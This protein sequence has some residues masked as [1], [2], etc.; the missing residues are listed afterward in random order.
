MHVIPENVQETSTTT[1]T[2]TL[3]LGGAVT[4]ALDFDS[5]LASADTTHYAIEDGVDLE[6]GIG[7]FT[8]P[9]TLTRD[10]VLYS[11]AGAGVKVNWGAG[12]RNVIGGLPGAE[13]SSLLDPADGVGF[14]SR[15][16]ARTYAARTLT[17]DRG[18]RLTNPGGVG[19]DPVISG[20]AI[21]IR[22]FGAVEGVG[23][24]V[25]NNVAFLLAISYLNSANAGAVVFDEGIWVWNAPINWGGIPDHSQIIG[26]GVV[27]LRY[28]GTGVAFNLDGGATGPGVHNLKVG[29]FLIEAP[30]TATI[31]FDARA[32]HHSDLRINVR[33]AGTISHQLAWCVANICNFQSS[34][35]QGGWYSA[36]A[37]PLGLVLNGRGTAFQTSYNT[38]IN[39]LFEGQPI[40]GQLNAALGNIFIGGAFEGCATKGLEITSSTENGNNVFLG[41][42]FEQNGPAFAGPDIDCDSRDNEFHGVDTFRNLLL[43]ANAINNKVIGGA[44]RDITLTAGAQSN[45]L[46]GFTIDRF[47]NVPAGSVIGDTTV[48][49][50]RDFTDNAGNLITEI[51]RTLNPTSFPNEVSIT[52]GASPFT[53]TNTNTVTEAVQVLSDQN[54]TDVTYVRNG[55]GNNISTTW[56]MWEVSPGDSLIVTYPDPAGPSMRAIARAK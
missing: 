35:N 37:P 29:P 4:G 3:T 8:P 40:G 16:A 47:G 7:T 43:G 24:E 32:I 51:G 54:V 45:I 38:F 30:S 20:M 23:N 28:T 41:T 19:G 12:T 49:I 44:H 34:V 46:T 15:T 55:V 10:T 13:I 11:T 33:G 39:P 48:N 21:N 31:G 5:Q 9:S 22:E 50:V 52:V 25:G 1:G 27:R 26:L 2:G 14:L 56:G 6:V 42:D 53:Y 18:V 17:A 36:S